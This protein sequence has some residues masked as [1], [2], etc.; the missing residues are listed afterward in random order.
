MKS[1]NI[2]CYPIFETNQ[3]LTSTQLNRLREFLDKD[4]RI[5]RLNIAGSG[6]VS[7]LEAE[8]TLSSSLL[9]VKK[10]YGITSDGY[11]IINE[12]ELLLKRYKNYILPEDDA[13]ELFIKNKKQIDIYELFPDNTKVEGTQPISKLTKAKLS[14]KVVVLF[15]EFFDERLNTCTGS[16]CDNKGKRRTC[17]VK[18]LLINQTD[19]FPVNLND[20][21][22]EDDGLKTIVLPTLSSSI[23]SKLKDISSMNEIHT[24]YKKIVNKYKKELSD[25]LFSAHKNYAKYL[26]LDALDTKPISDLKSLNFDKE[27]S[28]YAYDLIRDLIL[29][30]N[31][32][33][34]TANF[35]YREAVFNKPVFPRH[36]MLGKVYPVSGS[37]VENYRNY[38]IN[39]PFKD[40]LDAK[41]L[42]AQI[43]FKRILA[44]IEN[45][46]SQFKQK[47]KIKITPGIITSPLS[48]EAIPYY[49]NNAKKIFKL[50]NAEL[51]I[52]N[53]SKE[54]L[55]YNENLY[56]TSPVI[57]FVKDPL[58][59]RYDDKAYY[60]IEGHLGMNYQTVVQKLEAYKMTY[61]L[62]FNVVP[63][64]AKKPLNEIA[65]KKNCYLNEY[66]I[67]Y[68][69]LRENFYCLVDNAVKAVEKDEDKKNKL[70]IIEILLKLKLLLPFCIVDFKY[71]EYVKYSAELLKTLI[72]YYVFL[73]YKRDK[74]L[75]EQYDVLPFIELEQN[76]TLLNEKLEAI[77]ALIYACYHKKVANIVFSFTQAF[78]NYKKNHLSIFSN[79]VNKFPG[80][81][82]IAG[83]L[84][85]GTFILVY[86]DSQ[87]E[88]VFAD[89]ALNS[90]C[91]CEC[92][93]EEL[94]KEFEKPP[95]AETYIAET[96]VGKKMEIMINSSDDLIQ[97]NDVNVLNISTSSKGGQ[98]KFD[99]KDKLFNYTPAKQFKGI[100]IFEYTIVDKT[101]DLTSFA[102]VVVLVRSEYKEHI[103][104]V[105]DL[106]VVTN[107][108]TVVE[109]DVLAND[110]VYPKT[111]L[112]FDDKKTISIIT[113]LQAKADIIKRVIKYSPSVEGVDKFSYLLLDEERNESSLADVT[114]IVMCCEQQKECTLK[115]ITR[116][117]E[118]NVKILIYFSKAEVKENS[119]RFDYDSNMVKNIEIIKQFEFLIIPTDI[120]WEFGNYSFRYSAFDLKANKECSAKIIL[121]TKN[122]TP[123]GNINIGKET[124]F[125]LI[126]SAKYKTVIESNE[127]L[128][129]NVGKITNYYSTLESKMNSK[130][131]SFISGS[132]NTQVVE[133]TKKIVDSLIK[134]IKKINREI[135]DVGKKPELKVRKDINLELLSNITNTFL[136]TSS[137]N[138]KDIAANSKTAMYLNKDL[139]IKIKLLGT[140]NIKVI[141][142][143][144]DVALNPNK[145]RFKKFISMLGK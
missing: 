31:E 54:N 93:E 101:T 48:I 70:E 27:I 61:N 35:I 119:I 28:Q 67:A 108:T 125:T 19:L 94:C 22:N 12:N 129:K 113:P 72:E 137:L 63:L 24:G 46:E 76:K 86:D 126:N 18:V 11:L 42:Q 25:A 6:I 16:D 68:T 29:A 74:L 69:K 34:D 36:L 96:V 60:R 117:V 30:Y 58:D 107:K 143:K 138:K 90:N 81:E 123:G 39:T 82:H 114:V 52:K 41:T 104:A 102:F 17:S 133:N 128:R 88:E 20:F 21:V 65:L 53:R 131:A 83:V 85:G 122:V 100:E 130:P 75:N 115:D 1:N 98:L 66:Q 132:I 135:S 121:T 99:E 50:W 3:I 124:L 8:F 55:S 80:P 106:S 103:K 73:K 77:Y 44:M 91:C 141:T 5:T 64:Q 47:T 145:T 51:E 10:G 79:F 4:N 139:S 144:L 15:L 136:N 140:S 142:R 78:E 134:E 105:D 97:N 95:F 9:S 26:G 112:F 111:D 7:G 110:R 118:R 33:K 116:L 71:E 2:N 23:L 43:L 127:A 109:I 38:F 56:N 13:Y 59:F 89:F 45:F 84:K 92:C 120:F 14:N 49:Y 62:D 32:F 37:D 87:K 40:D 57:P